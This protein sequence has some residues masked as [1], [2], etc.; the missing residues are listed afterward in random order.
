M[1]VPADRGASVLTIAVTG[2]AMLLMVGWP[3]AGWALTQEFP[4][5][6]FDRVHFSGAGTVHLTQGTSA[7]LEAQGT[8]NILEK[9]KI[10]TRDGVLYIEARGLARNLVV[11]LRVANLEEFVAEGEARIRGVG[12]RFDA[13]RL[14]GNG[15]GSFHMERLEARELQVRSRGATRF[16]LTGQVGQQVVDLSGTGA[17]RAG[18]LISN[19]ATISVS[20]A[21]S[22]LLWADEVLDVQVAGSADIRYAGSPRVHQRISG[23]ASILRIGQIVI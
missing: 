1:D 14:E 13:L 17:Y 3:A 22:V 12:L 21:S 7:H 20:G 2:L 9:L 18:Q 16:D 23:V 4:V 8:S 6:E 10:E 5:G 15:G 11:Q 19:R